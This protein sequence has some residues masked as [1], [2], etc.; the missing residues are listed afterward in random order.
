MTKK[1]TRAQGPQVPADYDL[2]VVSAMQALL[3]GDADDVQ[4]KLA[5]Q[6]IIEQAAGTYEFQYYPSER[7]TAFALGRAHVGQQ[8]VKLLK[9]NTM[10]LRRG[11]Q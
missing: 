11:E 2:P 5:L 6:W 9:L 4:Q 3:A 8:I 7:D 10:T 1:A